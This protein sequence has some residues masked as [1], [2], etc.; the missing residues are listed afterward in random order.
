MGSFK[1]KDY[2]ID[3]PATPSKSNLRAVQLPSRTKREQVNGAFIRGPIPVMWLIRCF[4]LGL[5]A[6]KIGL[7]LFYLR[8]LCKSN[9][10]KVTGT[11]GN[12]FRISPKHNYRTYRKMEEA[13]LI[14]IEELRSGVAPTV[15]LLLGEYYVTRK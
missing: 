8:G 10:V 4:F 9:T 6:T 11:A 12:L 3:R 13:G 7:A 1:L 14:R 15:T 5:A 2:V